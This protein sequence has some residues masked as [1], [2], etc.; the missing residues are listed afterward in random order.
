MVGVFENRGAEIDAGPMRDDVTREWR[1]LH[2]NERRA[3]QMLFW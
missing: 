3:H 2:K 1:K